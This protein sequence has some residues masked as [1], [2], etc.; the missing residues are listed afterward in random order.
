MKTGEYLGCTKD[1]EGKILEKSYSDLNGVIL[2]QIGSLQVIKDGP[3]I[4]YIHEQRTHR[5][6][7]RPFW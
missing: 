2:Y 1:Y 4:T 5:L 3:M 7:V 6:S